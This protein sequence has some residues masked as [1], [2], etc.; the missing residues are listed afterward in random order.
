MDLAPDL[1]HLTEDERKIIEAVIN[2]QKVEEKRDAAAIQYEKMNIFI[3]IYLFIHLDLV[4]MI[5]Q[6][7]LLWLVDDILNNLKHIHMK[8][9]HM[10]QVFVVKYVKKRNLLVNNQHVNV[11]YVKNVFVYD[12]VYD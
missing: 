3:F 8:V 2:R 6:H 4:W 5:I 12:V 7:Q 9:H 11:Q 10:N 1:S